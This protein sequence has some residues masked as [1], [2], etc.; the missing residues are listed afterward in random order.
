MFKKVK[1]FLQDVYS[2]VIGELYTSPGYQAPTPRMI[3]T[4]EPD[5]A[6]IVRRE[7][8]EGDL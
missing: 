6:V 5:G 1:E 4:V 7:T 3:T 8:V 2:P